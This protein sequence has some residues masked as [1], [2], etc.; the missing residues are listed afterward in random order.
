MTTSLEEISDEK[1]SQDLKE[2]SF[3]VMSMLRLVFIKLQALKTL[4]TL[5]TI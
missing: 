5:K 2:P 3:M 4:Q 1:P